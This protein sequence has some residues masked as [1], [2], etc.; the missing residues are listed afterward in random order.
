MKLSKQGM[1]QP[2]ESKKIRYPNRVRLD[3]RELEIEEELKE[4]YKMIRCPSL[5]DP[6]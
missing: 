3:E 6:R 2:N 1:D 5:G 4:T